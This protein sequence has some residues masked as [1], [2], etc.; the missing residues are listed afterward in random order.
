MTRL[1]RIA[2][3]AFVLISTTCVAV[4][5]GLRSVEPM[6]Q[7]GGKLRPRD[8]VVE[9][10]YEHGNFGSSA[11]LSADGR[12]ALVGGYGDRENRGAV[13][14]FSRSGTTWSQLGPKLTASNEI[15]QGQFGYSVALARDGRTALVGGPYDNLGL[16]A[17]WLFARSGSRW[18]QE[19]RL[20]LGKPGAAVEA[21]GFGGSVDLSG[22]GDTAVVG[23]STFDTAIGAAFVYERRGGVWARQGK[24]L[25]GK[26]E[27]GQAE[28]GSAVALAAD[29]NTAV[30]GGPD[31]NRGIGAAW[32][33]LRTGS[34]WKQDGPKL[35]A[36]GERGHGSF[37]CSASLSSS[38]TVAVI[39]ACTDDNAA[40]AAWVFTRSGSSW[41]Q[42]PKLVPAG[43]SRRAVFGYDV[44]LTSDGGKALIG[45][46]G[47][48]RSTGAAWI[49]RRSGSTW[50]QVG[51]NLTGPGAEGP[52]N[53]GYSAAISSDGDTALLGG[54]SDSAGTGAAWV[55]VARR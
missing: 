42:G 38:G 51:A 55:K 46:Y 50:I 28:F 31:D 41:V 33:F 17:A 35:V 43:K 8:Q 9:V 11:A 39:G 3:V 10:G 36:R 48:E 53:L 29:G 12:T 22:S 34:T 25:T 6:A 54:P 1:A 21:D 13:W 37:G 19:A 47:Y 49:F 14:V 45:G 26:D 32:V 18:K 52:A 2:I 24:A 27:V 40:G 23:A 20:D 7:Q 44:A 16:G 15:G 4:A 5:D 30:I